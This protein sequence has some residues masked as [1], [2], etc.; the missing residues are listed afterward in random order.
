V[1]VRPR[2]LRARLTLVST[3]GAAAVLGLCLV[4]LYSGLD[5]QLSGALDADLAGRADDLAAAVRS[6]DPEVVAADPL[7]QLYA[8]DGTVVTGTASL[9]GRRLMSPAAVEDL[10]GG[11]VAD[12]VLPAGRS[13]GT[14]PVRV[15]ARRLDDGRVLAVGVS[16]SPLSAARRGLLQVLL[17][18]A[19]LLLAA[20]AAG[21]WL[22]VR[23]ALRPVDVLT[24][25]AAAIASFPSDRS[26]PAVPGDDEVAR[27]AATLD[28]ML[29]RLRVAFE[30]ER[31]FVDDASHELRT[32]IAVLRGEV[33][34][35]LTA[36]PGSGEAEQA[37]RAALREAERLST[38]ADGLLLLAR[39][40]TGTAVV[41][42]EP[43]D[44]LDLV[45]D[46]SARLRRAL[47]IAV[48][49]R[50]EPVVLPGDADR[51]RQ[52]LGN[53]LRNSAEAGAVRARV[54]IATDDGEAVL[55]VADDGPG[56]PAGLEPAAFDR[57][58][59]GGR[60]GTGAGLGLSIVRAVAVA[61][62]GTVSAAARGALGG[63]VV[64]VRLPLA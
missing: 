4:L 60:T 1:R 45:V 7:A 31:A 21:A 37:L 12:R 16:A 20:L 15:L 29:S 24:R 8:P 2:S 56:L 11:R 26:L 64:S 57:F 27:L 47:G 13:D 38:L 63:A 49:V 55:E 48:E 9:G 59:R 30:R 25:E 53:L 23:A 3:L 19:P 33:E 39:E 14:L 41:R 52:L 46:E 62:G 28:G 5:R 18:A 6:R 54:R 36:A 43:V 44:L 22:L 34:L 40:R 51:L 10:A 42:R 50:G 58:V 35:A 17:V 32:P 61:H